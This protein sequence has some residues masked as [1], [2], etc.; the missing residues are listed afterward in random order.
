MVFGILKDMANMAGEVVGT[1]AGIPIALISETLEVPL[2]FVKSA[3]EAGCD[4]VEEIKDWIDD[5]R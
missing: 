1:V 2:E 5:N 4:T 3:K